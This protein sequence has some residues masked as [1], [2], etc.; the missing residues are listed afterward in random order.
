M[1]VNI[2]LRHGLNKKKYIELLQDCFNNEKLI[3]DEENPEYIFSIGG[4]G[5][6]LDA[7]KKYGIEP[8]FIP[9][10]QGNLGFYTSW[11]IDE[12]SKLEHDILKNNLIYCPLLQA[13][14]TCNNF[15]EKIY[16]AVNDLTIINPLQTLILNIKINDENFESFRGT[17]LCFS[18]PMGSTAYNKSLGGAI[19]VNNLDIFQL[20]TIAP[21]NNTSYRTIENP[22]IFGKNSVVSIT[23]EISD[24]ENVSLVADRQAQSLSNM[25]EI[26][27]SLVN[28]EV[29]ILTKD[30]FGFWKRIHKAFVSN[31]K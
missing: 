16:Y 4:D 3:F 5:T 20:T 29:K 21:I 14:I 18:T 7:V 26:E 9:I 25:K 22:I 23:A 19:V 10:N 30:G 17:G 2:Y 27:I 15:E 1:R 31:E 28:K 24:L 13:K 12:I 6:L 8:I 11:T